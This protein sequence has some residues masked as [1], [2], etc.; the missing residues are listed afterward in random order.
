MKTFL[1][2]HK[3]NA[4]ICCGLLMC[5]IAVAQD[6]EQYG[7]PFTGVPDAE[8]A[9]IYQV[10]MR[11]F[12]STRNFQGVTDRLDD[13]KAL[14]VNVI[15]LMPF[16]PVGTL[17][18]FNS[19]YCIKDLY[20]VGLE[21]GTLDDLRNLVDEAHD[22][23]MAVMIDW[24]PN[25]TSW[26]HPWIT[27]HKDWYL[28]DNDGN[29]IQLNNY[30]DVA[31]LDFSNTEMREEMI[32]AMR[33]WVFTANI[34]GFRCDF[35]DHP[36][37]DFWQEAITS[38]RSI[39][40]HKLLLL[41]EGSR[42]TNYTAGFDLNFGFQFYN[43]SLKPIYKNGSSAKLIDN[44][45]NT[46]YVNASD[47]QRVAR[48]LS[49]HD[50]YGSD[51]SPYINFSG[52]KGTLA[53]FVITAFMKS[54]PFIYNGMEVGNTVA[55][56]FPF[57]SSVI[58]WTE[59]ESITPEMT[60]I[61]SIRNVSTAIRRGGLTSYTNADV[62]AFT[63]VSGTEGVFVLS[64]LRNAEKTFTI[65]AG[66]ANTTW[67]DELSETE[68]TI[69]DTLSLAAYEYKVF[70]T[71][72][73]VSV[74]DREFSP[75]EAPVLYPSPAENGWFM[76]TLPGGFSDVAMSIFDLQGRKV[77]TAMLSSKEST[78]N[79]TGLKKGMY[80]VAFDS[81]LNNDYQKILVK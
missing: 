6:P 23:G 35:A 40:T 65:P 61:I 53:A 2:I 8:D 80:I 30:S 77:L 75:S 18:A 60:K 52:K 68:V 36:P 63:K 7:T 45:N 9:V 14:G 48:Y 47:T 20:A 21:Y 29:I 54:V 11:C 44:S 43:S 22:K 28:Q 33:Y 66:I 70:S 50:I 79:I 37:V 69:G 62:C 1:S 56:P 4:W 15:Y 39:T 17:K 81:P 41:A 51:G 12:C 64:N 19:P 27:E 5:T 16:Y 73:F 55:M 24:V 59:D 46:E 58:N 76:V 26:D 38:L 34:D 31:A 57:T 49:N 25:Q 72:N 71:D 78:V 32:H 3:V 42:S 74:R 10:N 13:I 67:Y